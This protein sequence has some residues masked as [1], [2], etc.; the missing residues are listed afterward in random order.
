M[1]VSGGRGNNS[2]ISTWDKKIIIKTI[3]DNEREIFK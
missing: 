1:K 2:L 3:D